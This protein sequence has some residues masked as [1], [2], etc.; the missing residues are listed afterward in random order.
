M[1][2]TLQKEK[3]GV[4]YTWFDSS[5]ILFAECN[6]NTPTMVPTLLI[7]NPL[8]TSVDVPCYDVIIV[9]RNGAMYKYHNV[10]LNDYTAFIYHLNRDA[11]SSTGKGFNKYIKKYKTEKLGDNAVEYSEKKKLL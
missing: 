5:H 11:P 9:F 10:E 3:D 1:A 6:K 2:I 8:L 7:E 4:E